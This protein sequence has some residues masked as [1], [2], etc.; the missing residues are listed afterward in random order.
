M[1]AQRACMNAIEVLNKSVDK[2]RQSIAECG[3]K[4]EKFRRLHD[5]VQGCA[6]ELNKPISDLHDGVGKLDEIYKAIKEY[7]ETN[8]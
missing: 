8:I 2:L 7:E 3:W 1:S 5:I 6:I 4:D